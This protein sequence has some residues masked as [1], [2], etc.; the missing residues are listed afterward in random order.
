MSNE[1]LQQAL[2][3]LEYHT[4]QTRPIQRTEAAIK[5][6]REAI[7]Q[8]VQPV[9]TN[10]LMSAY[11]AIQNCLLVVP[12]GAFKNEMNDWLECH[13]FRQSPKAQPVQPST[14]LRD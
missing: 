14:A 2:D 9:E 8:P 5:M 1:L 13:L 12:E 11:R 6:L 4:E 10:N 7:A 3:A